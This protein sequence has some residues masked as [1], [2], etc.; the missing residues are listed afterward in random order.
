[1]FLPIFYDAVH[2]QY[3]FNILLNNE[4]KKIRIGLISNLQVH[5]SKSKVNQH[6]N[7]H[8]FCITTD[9]RG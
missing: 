9:I 5:R 6:N 2:C 3:T 7:V 1:M 8:D 4:K